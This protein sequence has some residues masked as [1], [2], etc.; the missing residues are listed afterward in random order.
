M[1]KFSAG[2]L[3][4]RLGPTMDRLPLEVLL[5]HPG[6]PYWARKDD[7]AWSI[8]KG[9]YLADEDPWL[10]AQREFR[11]ELGVGAPAGPALDLG[12]VTQSGGKRV[13][14]WAVD[15]DLDVSIIESNTFDLEWPPRSGEMQTFPEVDRAAWFDPTVARTKLVLAQATFVD[16][17]LDALADPA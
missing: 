14:A 4:Y 1:A 15:G 12:S 5:V 9:E 6:G 17:L 13:Q 8:P 2:L 16:R 7:H 11:E 10:A 3:V